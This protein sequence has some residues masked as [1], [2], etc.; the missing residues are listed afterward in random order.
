VSVS[1]LDNLSLFIPVVSKDDADIDGLLVVGYMVFG[2]SVVVFGVIAC[3]IAACHSYAPITVLR[4]LTG[5]FEAVV[6]TG[7]LY[8]AQWYYP[9][10][11]GTRAGE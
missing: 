6:Q 2:S 9:N 4:L 3:S 10:E 1:L 7:N 11:V 8:L 5:A